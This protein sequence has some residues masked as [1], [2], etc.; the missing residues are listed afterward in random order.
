[1]KRFVLLFCCFLCVGFGGSRAMA[2]ENVTI[3]CAGDDKTLPVRAERPAV[4]ESQVLLTT[5][6]VT[7]IDDGQI[8]VQG[9][10][11]YPEIVLNVGRDTHLV[12]GK[13]GWK[14]KMKHFA[15]GD[16]VDAYYRPEVTRSLPP[17]GNALAIVKKKDGEKTVNARY[18]KAGEVTFDESGAIVLNSNGDLLIRIDKKA[19]RGVKEICAGD[20]LLVWYEIVALSMPGKATAQKAKLL[21]KPARVN[22]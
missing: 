6:T 8:T 12:S 1:M 3:P 20:D 21:E 9:E 17:Q 2:A 7:S 22:E 19:F 5:G 13:S 10:G 14:L 11:S 18:I 16:K 15:V 4:M